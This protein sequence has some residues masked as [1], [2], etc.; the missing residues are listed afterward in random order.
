MALAQTLNGIRRELRTKGFLN[1]LKKQHFIPGVVYGQGRQPLPIALDERTLTRAF[2]H[3]GYRGLF[4][5]ELE[6]DQRPLMALVREVQRHPVNGAYTHV[7][8]LAVSMTEKITSVVPIQVTGEEQVVERGGTL[9]WGAKEV[10]VTCLPGDLPDM[11]RCDVSELNI[12]DKITFEDLPVLPTVEKS[13]DPDTLVVIVLNAD[14]GSADE[15]AEESVESQ[16]ESE[17]E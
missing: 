14:R 15:P 8:L 4:S 17:S 6:G 13:G 2:T 11:V 9:Q 10:E 16:G 3:Y 7:D 1:D 12:G 5:L